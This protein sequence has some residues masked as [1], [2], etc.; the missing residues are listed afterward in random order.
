MTMAHQGIKGPLWFRR[1][2]CL[3]C[4]SN[5]LAVGLALD[6]GCK[7]IGHRGGGVE[8]YS[9]ISIAELQTDEDELDAVWLTQPVTQMGFEWRIQISFERWN[10]DTQRT[11]VMIELLADGNP[12]MRRLSLN[13][14]VGNCTQFGDTGFFEP[15]WYD[16]TFWSQEPLLTQWSC[17]AARWDQIP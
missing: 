5:R 2:A 14:S 9:I 13:T 8:V 15:D 16:V 4:T 17:G 7:W 6:T 12:N 11:Q 1:D 10:F 3:A